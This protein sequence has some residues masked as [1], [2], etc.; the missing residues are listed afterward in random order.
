MIEIIFAGLAFIVALLL[1]DH[2]VLL[3]LVLITMIG[4][5]NELVYWRGC[6]EWERRHDAA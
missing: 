6:R 4:I 3:F 2:P 1:C 5:G